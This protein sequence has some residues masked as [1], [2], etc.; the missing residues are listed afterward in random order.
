MP[1]FFSS[2]HSPRPERVPATDSGRT[3]S[4]WQEDWE[5]AL[6]Q[7]PLSGRAQPHHHD[8]ESRRKL[9]NRL[10]RIE[11]H[12]HG[13]RTMIEQGQPCPDVLLQIAA[14]KGA[15]DRVARLILDDHIRHCLRHAIETGNLEVELEELQRALDR[16]IS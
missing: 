3:D 2:A 1:D 6:E 15:L 13:I 10:A 7:P 5:L 9:V 4:D 11:G 8:P 14:V 12:V 16:F